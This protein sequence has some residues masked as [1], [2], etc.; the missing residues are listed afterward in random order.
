MKSPTDADGSKDASRA[1][2]EAI[3]LAPENADVKSAFG[4]IQKDDVEHALKKLCR[5]L[6]SE[7]DEAAG[8]EALQYLDRS[9][10]V[11][12][13]VARECME[14]VMKPRKA[15]IREIQDGIFAGLLRESTAAKAFL[16]KTLKEC[17]T[18][19]AFEDIYDLGDGAANGIA[20][21]VSDPSA[22]PSEA[23]REAC[24]KDMFQ[25]YLAKLLQ[26]GDDHNGRALKGIA[27]L[28]AADAEKLHGYIDKDCF[29][30]ILC[31][32]DGRNSIEVRSQATLATAKYL[33][34]AGDVGQQ[35]L[36]QFVAT[37]VTRQYT[38]DLVL[39]FSAA[40]GVFPVAPSI[41]SALFLTKGFV[42][43]LVPLL[44]KKAKSEKV[45]Q[46]ALE[47]LSAACIHSACRE[48][49]SKN[50]I[51][52]LQHIMETGKGK[53]PGLAAVILAKLQGPAGASGGTK[54]SCKVTSDGVD[55]LVPRL[56][57]MMADDTEESKQS[58]IEGLAYASVQPKIKDQL[59]KDDSFLKT[60]LKTLN[61]SSPA[62][63]V[64]F[65][66]LTIFDSL[67]RFLPNLSEEQK[68]LSQ[69]KAYAN[70]SKAAPKADPLDEAS[71]V[72]ERCKAVVDAGIVPVLANLSRRLSPTSISIVFNIMLSISRVTKA[73]GTIA[74][75]GGVRLLLQNYAAST[76]T[77]DDDKRSRRKAAHALALIL[78]STDPSLLFP[79]SGSL[80]LTSVI[81]PLLSLLTEDPSLPT[82]GPRDLLP[83]FEAL[84][85]LTNLASVPSS[86]PSETIISQSWDTIEDLLLSNNALIQRAATQLI[87]NLVNCAKGIELFA[88]DSA[89]AARRLHVLL[90][91]ADVDERDTRKA[92]GGALASVTQFEGTVKAILSR[93][94]GI[95][96]L[97]SLCED[98]DEEIVHRGVV[99][100][101]NSICME[102]DVGRQARRKVQERRGL[103][104]LEVITH[105]V[106]SRD[107]RDLSGETL[108]ALKQQS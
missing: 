42:P 38:E 31:C 36:S 53:R 84:L 74:Q 20:V 41:A 65:G 6:V 18:N 95:N 48:A 21:V 70:A 35:A 10:E 59:A 51:P 22:W 92:A 56:K 100:I 71:A 23:S 89:A 39:A 88:D 87:C 26:V 81:R 9:T 15:S 1:L 5:K 94:R 82:E 25:L 61:A 27:R 73:R 33:E 13:D 103:E 4:K 96:I 3:S 80:P 32:L 45:E 107:I 14:I 37:K 68:R 24:E 86:A 30:L 17:S 46:A 91:M 90:A 2:R 97:L 12:G 77:S 76:G 99:C 105:N 60:L 57:R 34:V 98:E 69:L 106:K 43:A 40:A 83:S 63:P 7:G 58:S 16:A 55:D 93:E 62:S 28:L 108:K 75:Q 8:K 78:I 47:M 102:G 79:A 54:T 67:T 72:T 66:G 64:V 49:I 101:L 104:I 11:P 44:E 29:D 50:C 19:L 52:W 85:A